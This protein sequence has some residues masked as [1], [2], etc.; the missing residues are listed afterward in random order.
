M[1]YVHQRQRHL[2]SRG[3]SEVRLDDRDAV[4]GEM[5]AKTCSV[6]RPDAFGVEDGHVSIAQVKADTSEGCVLPNWQTYL[7]D[8]CGWATVDA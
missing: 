8:G 1:R 6:E 5:S 7:P 2:A 4:S 3:T